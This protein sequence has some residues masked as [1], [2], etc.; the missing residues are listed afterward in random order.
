MVADLGEACKELRRPFVGA[1]H[2]FKTQVRYPRG[3]P[4]TAIVVAYVTRHAIATRLDAV[5][6]PGGWWVS[7]REGANGFL[8]G[9]DKQGQD[10]F[11]VPCALTVLGVTKETYGEGTT[12]DRAEANALMRAARLFGVGRYLVELDGVHVRIGNGPGEV[13]PRGA[14][15]A[16]LVAWLREGLDRRLQE[17]YVER[18]GEPLGAPGHAAQASENGEGA[19][20]GE[21]PEVEG[22]VGISAPV[23]DGAEGVTGRGTE[24]PPT[25][26]RHGEGGAGVAQPTVAPGLAGGVEH[27]AARR[28]AKPNSDLGELGEGIAEVSGGPARDAG[29]PAAE[30]TAR[31]QTDEATD[32]LEWSTVSISA[33]A[34]FLYGERH[35]DRLRQQ[36]T[37]EFRELLDAA[38]EGRVSESTLKR[39]LTRAGDEPNRTM[40]KARLM[41]WLFERARKAERDEGS[42]DE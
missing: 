38:A 13:P 22:P 25:D 26:G 19:D 14:L 33:L 5:V 39:Q 31:N 37:G 15:K 10:V 30:P 27:E 23:G 12:V 2:E 28:A 7:Y 3:N 1:A 16:A 9:K 29:R 35:V 41:S 42:A 40:A 17:S 24:M 6:G 4:H 21:V 11:I 18:Y 32:R 8:M 36:E 34:E 20:A